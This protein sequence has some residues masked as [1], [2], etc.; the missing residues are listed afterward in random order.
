MIVGLANLS[1]NL[2]F[3]RFWIWFLSVYSPQSSNRFKF[4][5]FSSQGN[6]PFLW[7]VTRQR[8]VRP[9]SKKF[10]RNLSMGNPRAKLERKKAQ[11]TKN[12]LMKHNRLR[13]FIVYCLIMTSFAYSSLKLSYG[14]AIGFSFC[15]LWALLCFVHN[16]V[17][18]TRF[19][20]VRMCLFQVL[21][22]GMQFD[23]RKT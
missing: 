13:W 1:L 17:C 22:N 7:S 18:E 2:P 4:F 9:Q 20:D 10:V 12:D 19:V 21:E 8:H 3:S 6:R 16:V 23:N 14:F 11:Q 15:W 5:Q